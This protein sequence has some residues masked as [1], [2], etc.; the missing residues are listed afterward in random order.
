MPF[1]SEDLWQRFS[2]RKPE[3]A[4]LVSPW[5]AANQADDRL[6]VEMELVLSL[7]A[8]IRNHRSS[9]GMSP[10]EEVK[11]TLNISGQL[12]ND[13]VGLLQKIANAQISITGDSSAAMPRT[14]G[15]LMIEVDES[16]KGDE[17]D[18][19]E[20]E[21]VYLKGFLESV[22]RKLSNEKFVSGAPASVIDN[23][24]KKQ[25]DAREKIKSIEE[26]L[27]VLS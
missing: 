10:K 27:A 9:L 22:D 5:P 16:Q 20:K 26:R 3:N 25:S 21:M 4:L 13:F 12:E 19:L 15:V 7:V 2:E 18:K 6:L 24:K 1:I 17:R 11:G 14:N 23:E 8:E